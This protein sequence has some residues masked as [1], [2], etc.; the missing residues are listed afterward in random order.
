MEDKIS[1]CQLQQRL[2][3]AVDDAVPGY[4]WVTAEIGEVKGNPNGHW[5]FELVDYDQEGKTIAAKARATIW[6]RAASL[7]IPYFTT[8]AGVPLAAGM[9]LLVKVQV[10]YSAVY[11]LSLN[12]LDIDPSYTIGE[13]ELE[14]QR[15]INRLQREGMFG[16]NAQ[17]QLPVLPKRLAVISSPAAAGYRDFMKHLSEQESG[18]SVYTR[19]FVAPMQGAD[20]PQGIIAALEAVADGLSAD[21]AYDA[22]VIIRGGGSALEL[23]CYDDYELALN[24]AQFPLPVIVGVGHDHDFHVADMVA[25]T[26]CK[27]PTAV[28]DFIIGLYMEQ[29]ARLEAMLHRCRI[30][31]NGIIAAEEGKLARFAD[32]LKNSCRMMVADKE[33]KLN[34]VEFKIKAMDPRQILQ[35]GFAMVA[36]EDGR[37]LVSADDIPSGGKMKLFMKD[38][39]VELDFVV[40]ERK[41]KE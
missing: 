29:S 4:V 41:G 33:N 34:F 38:G 36:G 35:R 30:A 6:S 10:Q 11:G 17:L 7:L 16:V 8:T 24:I 18:V 20:A 12:I 21:E 15:V 22:V 14:R 23:A 32:R 3:G 37:R 39:V 31:L 9:R 28:A 13:F 27:T 26:S 19:L 5:Y 1:L 2:K 40:R 25:H